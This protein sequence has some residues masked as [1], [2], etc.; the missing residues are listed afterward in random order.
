MQHPKHQI[1]SFFLRKTSK[2]KQAKPSN[3]PSGNSADVL[4]PF[5]S[6]S[7]CMRFLTILTVI[8][9]AMETE[10]VAAVTSAVVKMVLQTKKCKCKQYS[11]A[12]DFVLFCF[13]CRNMPHCSEMFQTGRNQ[14]PAIR[15]LARCYRGCCKN[16]LQIN[17]G[18]SRGMHRPKLSTAPPFL[19]C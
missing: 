11:A 19:L 1:T 2:T 16:H 18:D 17:Q 15:D 14:P 4:Q 12:R 10:T 8:L 3:V 7:L 13:S 6:L 9:T 5:S